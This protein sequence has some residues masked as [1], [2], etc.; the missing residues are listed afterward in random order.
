MSYGYSC[1]TKAVL[2]SKDTLLIFTSQSAKHNMPRP[3]S[4]M[5][6]CL[7]PPPI[8]SLS[9]MY[10]QPVILRMLLPNHLLLVMTC[11]IMDTL[12]HRQWKQSLQFSQLF[13]K[14]VP[15]RGDV[16]FLEYTSSKWFT[17]CCIFHSY[18]HPP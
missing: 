11:P 8:G 12:S 10:P 16:I 13:S 18:H 7:H 4:R 14:I 17:R 6:E 2:K 15:S 5:E 3:Y 1:L 9:S